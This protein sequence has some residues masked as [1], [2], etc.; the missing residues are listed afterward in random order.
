MELLIV[1]G[2]CFGAY[3]LLGVFQGCFTYN[4]HPL[5]YQPHQHFPELKEDGEEQTHQEQ[6]QRKSTC[7]ESVD[8]TLD[9]IKSE[10]CSCYDDIFDNDTI[11]ILNDARKRQQL[12]AKGFVFDKPISKFSLSSSLLSLN[13]DDQNIFNYIDDINNNKFY[14]FKQENDGEDD[15]NS[16]INSISNDKT[17]DKTSSNNNENNNENSSTIKN[18]QINNKKIFFISSAAT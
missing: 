2:L 18:V 11:T 17:S 9:S 16:S 3:E 8:D 6:E 14:K 10:S 13:R 7:D 15:D 4:E 1:L 5:P 12:P